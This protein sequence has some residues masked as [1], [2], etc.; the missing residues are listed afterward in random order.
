MTSR[1]HDSASVESKALAGGESPSVTWADEAKTVHGCKHY[2]THCS[3]KSNCCARWFTCRRCHDEQITDHKINRY[4][5]EEMFCFFCETVQPVAQTCRHCD[6]EMARYYCNICKL[7]SDGD[8]AHQIFHCA[9][10][11]LCRVGGALNHFR[12][13]LRP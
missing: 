2:R 1:F 13:L 5:T 7:W 6:K 10:C 12:I 9:K 4:A 11:G 8:N 3:V